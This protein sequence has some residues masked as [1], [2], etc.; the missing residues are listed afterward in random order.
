MLGPTDKQLG[1][2]I[3][4][5]LAEAHGTSAPETFDAFFRHVTERDVIDGGDFY[6]QDP[7]S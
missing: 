5:A 4:R 1:D 7:T 3:K 2:A 6:G